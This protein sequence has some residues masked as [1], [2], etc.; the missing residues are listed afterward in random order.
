MPEQAPSRHGGSVGRRAGRPGK[1]L[2][3][4]RLMCAV[5]WIGSSWCGSNEAILGDRGQIL[6][7]HSAVVESAAVPAKWTATNRTEIGTVTLMRALA[8]AVS[9]PGPSIGG[10]DGSTDDDVDEF[11][12]VLHT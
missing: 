8:E 6:R 7:V 4:G 1:W 10:V 3:R 12:T 2:Y 5:A 11:L 9:R